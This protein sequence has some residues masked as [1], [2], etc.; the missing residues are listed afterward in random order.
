M[1]P[2]DFW[3]LEPLAW[4]RFVLLC[5]IDIMAYCGARPK[6]L[7][8]LCRRHVQVVPTEPVITVEDGLADLDPALSKEVPGYMFAG[9]TAKGSNSHKRLVRK[10]SIV[11]DP[12]G[13]QAVGD[14]LARLPV[15]PDTPLIGLSMHTINDAFKRLLKDCGLDGPAAAEGLPRSLYDLRHTYITQ[16]L[17]DNWDPYDVAKNT[18]TS[19]QMIERYYDH[20]EPETKFEKWTKRR[21][22]R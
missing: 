6:T 1:A 17:L 20:L 18:M 7:A 5:V 12:A 21:K 10:W 14:L 3:L 22:R 19:I 13:W 8:T 4:G 15:T 2:S 11:V 16:R 9:Q